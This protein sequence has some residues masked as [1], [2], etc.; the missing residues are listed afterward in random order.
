M[1]T[2]LQIFRCRV[3]MPFSTGFHTTFG[4]CFRNDWWWL[5]RFRDMQEMAFRNHF[6]NTGFL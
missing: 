5:L 2:T 6:A 3:R 4:C 1:K